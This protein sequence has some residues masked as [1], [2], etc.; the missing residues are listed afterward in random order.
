MAMRKDRFHA[1]TDPIRE[2]LQVMTGQEPPPFVRGYSFKG[3]SDEQTQVLQDW[4]AT[5][6]RPS[7][8]TGIGLMDA[9]ENQVAEAV[10]N[11]NIPPEKE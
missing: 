3:L 8:C 11:A 6:V 4:C 2:V 7:W 1:P 10:S 5:H 9:A